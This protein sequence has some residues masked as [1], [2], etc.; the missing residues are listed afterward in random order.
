[1]QIVPYEQPGSRAASKLD[2]A[3]RPASWI[4]AATTTASF[5]KTGE[6]TIRVTARV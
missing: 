2:G 6:L 5:L 4:I 3:M 1:M